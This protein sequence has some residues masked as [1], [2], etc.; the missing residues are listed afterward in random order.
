MDRDFIEL[1][2][3]LQKEY[4]ASVEREKDSEYV[5]TLFAAIT[6]D[7]TVLVSMTPDILSN[8]SKCILIHHQSSLAITYWYSWYLI[9]YINEIGAV[10]DSRLDDEFELRIVASGRY[11]N[12]MMQLSANHMTYCW[13][14]RPWENCIQSVW[15]LYL[16]LKEAKTASERKLIAS[17]FEKD[18][19]IL[20]LEKNNEDF[21][22][23]VHLLE[24]E[25]DQYK[26][27]LDEI[28]EMV[29]NGKK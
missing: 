12:Q 1:A 27:M 28:K 2:K 21:S 18:E 20:E 19:K 10:L 8:A 7:N 17:C 16:R 24:S 29:E 9:Q 4:K 15:N 26:Q 11:S 23:K 14:R 25:R 6:D 5:D 13:K 22:Y 3:N